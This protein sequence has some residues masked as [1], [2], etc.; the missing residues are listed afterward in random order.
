MTHVSTVQ[1]L[2]SLQL[3]GD[4]VQLVVHRYSW[5]ASTVCGSGHVA[6]AGTH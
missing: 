2:L 3:T 1:A 5:Q 4:F 6:A